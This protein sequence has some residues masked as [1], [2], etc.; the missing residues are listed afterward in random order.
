[1]DSGPS[2]PII[3]GKVA[4]VFGV[5]GWLKIHS[6]TEPR[7]NILQYSPWYLKLSKQWRRFEVLNGQP[8]GKGLIAQLVG[9]TDRDQAAE[10]VGAE[11]SI[12]TAQL[13]KLADDE[14][15][16]SDLIGLKVTNLQ[17]QALGTIQSI[18]PTGANDVLVIEQGTRQILIPYVLEHYVL[19]IDLAGGTMQV[20]WPWLDDANDQD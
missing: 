12:D 11:I 10:L 17:G 18:M 9:C 14:Y 3:I 6:E 4:G 15:Y 8:H 19:Q 20:D 5:K 16:W 7:T 1:M 2:H 13:P